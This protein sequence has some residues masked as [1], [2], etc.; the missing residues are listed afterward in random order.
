MAKI[1]NATEKELVV[2]GKLLLPGE[3]M[4][5]PDKLAVTLAKGDR[6]V[7]LLTGIVEE[8]ISQAEATDKRRGKGKAK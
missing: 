2:N 3:T 7:V 8:V 6:P 1:Q 4:E 5:V